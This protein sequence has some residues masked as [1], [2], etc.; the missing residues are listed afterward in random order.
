MPLGYQLMGF[1]F[2][3]DDVYMYVCIIFRGWVTDVYWVKELFITKEG[4]DTA[5]KIDQIIGIQ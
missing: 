4:K 2:V 1:V 3:C 5:V